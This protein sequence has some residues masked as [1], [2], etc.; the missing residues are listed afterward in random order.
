M[1]D[2][3]S[4]AMKKLEEGMLELGKGVEEMA[5][6]MVGKIFT[7]DADGGPTKIK[8]KK[9]STVYLGKNVYAKL[10]Q[11]VD[12]EIVDSEEASTEEEK[13]E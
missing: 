3:F 5:T 11:D 12:A 7:E 13:S 6:D 4:A 1:K 10:S 2:R 8:V 9:G